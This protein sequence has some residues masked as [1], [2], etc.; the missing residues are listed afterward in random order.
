MLIVLKFL[1]F[2]V[3]FLAVTLGMSFLPKVNK[4]TNSSK[5][6]EKFQ[7]IWFTFAGACVAF[8]PSWIYFIANVLVQPEGFWQQIALGALG[9]FF[10]GSFQLIFIVFYIIILVSVIWSK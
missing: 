6:G 5:Q 4:W 7:K 10:L 1:G 8:I 9:I 3:L 2:V